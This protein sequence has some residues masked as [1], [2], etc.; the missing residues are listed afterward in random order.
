MDKSVLY[1]LSYGLYAIGAQGGACIVNTVFQITSTPAVI[2]LSMNKD[3]A[4]HDLIKNQGHFSVS[5]LNEDVPPEIIRVLGF[6]SSR[7]TDKF[8][9]L[10]WKYEQGLPVL[11]KGSVGYLLCEIISSSDLGTH[12]VFFAAV[13]DAALNPSGQNSHV[14]TYEYYHNVIKGSAPKNAP[15]YQAPEAPKKEGYVCSVCGYFHEGELPE[16]FKC[17]VCGVPAEMFKKVS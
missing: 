13:K 16:G 7:D 3:N 9:G 8:S 10:P 6:T 15:T 14:M 2:A 5:I 4:T 11:E 1:K 17:P 12:T